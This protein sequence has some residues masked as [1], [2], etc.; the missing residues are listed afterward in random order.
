MKVHHGNNNSQ[1]DKPRRVNN[2]SKA[3]IILHGDNDLHMKM[4]GLIK[5]SLVALNHLSQEKKRKKNNN[6]MRTIM[7]GKFP[8]TSFG[9]KPRRLFFLRFLTLSLFEH[10]K[11][12]W[13]MQLSKHQPDQILSLLLHGFTNP[14]RKE[15]H[16]KIC[17]VLQSTLSRWMGRLLRQFSTFST[18]QELK[19]KLCLAESP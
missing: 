7:M 12:S 6:N 11:P 1:V 13:C 3:T 8:S 4:I 9:K 16:W 15:S 14:L 10:G 19:A 17:R 5:E 18:N 2:P